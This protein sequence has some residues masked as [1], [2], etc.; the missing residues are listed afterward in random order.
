MIFRNATRRRI[1]LEQSQQVEME[2]D[3]YAIGSDHRSRH[4]LGA[5]DQHNQELRIPSCGADRLVVHRKRC[6]MHLSRRLWWP[7]T[8]S[9]LS[10][11]TAGSYAS[12]SDPT[13]FHR[14]LGGTY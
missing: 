9:K 5:K 6:R 4:I 7:K 12:P 1:I 2:E 14:L 3:G 13:S 10:R 11:V 8:S